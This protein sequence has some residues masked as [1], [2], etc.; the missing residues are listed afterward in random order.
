M[1]FEKQLNAPKKQGEKIFYNYQ[2]FRIH[3][4][5]LYI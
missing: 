2:S 4:S 5:E 3:K 1:L